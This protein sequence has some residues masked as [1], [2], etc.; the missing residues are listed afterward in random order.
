M[1]VVSNGSSLIDR[2][3][4]EELGDNERI[5]WAGKPGLLA[6]VLECKLSLFIIG[7]YLATL[8]VYETYGSD[9]PFILLIVAV[10]W[11]FALVP[12]VRI[13]WAVVRAAR[14]VYAI[15]DSR[16]IMLTSVV[17]RSI[18][19]YAAA[20]F[21]EMSWIALGNDRGTIVL[22]PMP[23]TSVP[24]FRALISSVPGRMRD[25]RG[26]RDAVRAIE[27]IKMSGRQR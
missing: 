13:I 12:V 3:H 20:N 6:A 15:T 11:I 5:V 22:G 8:Y 27:R 16:V 24:S 4:N 10:G 26:L 7:S 9:N 25:V 17:R 1:A 19:S 14:T 18:R 2:L 21:G 23:R